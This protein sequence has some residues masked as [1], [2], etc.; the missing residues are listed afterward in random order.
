LPCGRA[1]GAAEIDGAM[2]HAPQPARH[3]I[4]AHRRR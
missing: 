4:M 3:A 1:G 2:Q